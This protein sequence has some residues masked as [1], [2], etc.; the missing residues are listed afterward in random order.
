MTTRTETVE[1]LLKE[2]LMKNSHPEAHLLTVAEATLDPRS[3]EPLP[4]GASRRMSKAEAFAAAAAVTRMMR[5]H[6]LTPSDICR[7]AK[8]ANHPTGYFP[9][10]LNQA[11]MD[12]SG[13]LAAP[14]QPQRRIHKGLLPYG[15]MVRAIA[16]RADVSEADLLQALGL[17]VAGYLAPF[18]VADRSPWDLIAEDVALLAPYLG[19]VRKG[20][21]GEPVDLRRYFSEAERMNVVFDPDGGRMVPRSDRARDDRGFDLAPGIPLYARTVAAGSVDCRIWDEGEDGEPFSIPVGSMEVNIVE[22]F[23]LE[24]VPDRKGLRVVMSAEPWTATFGN[25]GPSR[26]NPWGKG[27]LT[28]FVRGTPLGWGMTIHREGGPYGLSF[29]DAFPRFRCADYEQHVTDAFAGAEHARANECD[30]SSCYEALQ[31]ARRFD[32]D[33]DTLRRLLGRRANDPWR[34]QLAVFDGAPSYLRS[35][36]MPETVPLPDGA[37]SDALADRLREALLGEGQVLVTALMEAVT[38]R[39]RAMDAYLAERTDG[40]RWRRDRF[41]RLMRS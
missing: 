20:P 2:A 9:F 6:G 27:G 33:A 26:S 36:A 14:L 12:A 18:A 37:I 10:H 21:D 8:V 30:P 22:V 39:V 1:R 35:F 31:V 15:R 29:E 5:L 3:G 19:K 16:S 7:D 38:Q 25:T 4:K 40:E 23:R 13:A 34:Q 17:A 24:V 11:E 28:D 41:R 32:L